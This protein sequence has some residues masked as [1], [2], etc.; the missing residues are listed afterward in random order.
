MRVK[1]DYR[2]WYRKGNEVCD[3]LDF[4]MSPNVATTCRLYDINKD[5]ADCANEQP[6]AIREGLAEGLA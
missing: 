2:T 5:D 1:E 3:Y 4:I 6:W